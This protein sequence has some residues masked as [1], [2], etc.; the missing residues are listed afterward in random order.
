MLDTTASPPP[1]SASSLPGKRKRNHVEILLADAAN[2][3][4]IGT[5]RNLPK[6]PI[7]CTPPPTPPRKQNPYVKKLLSPSEHAGSRI[8]YRLNNNMNLDYN[9][10][11]DN[12]TTRQFIQ[13]RAAVNQE[14]IDLLQSCTT[15]C[16]LCDSKLTFS[17]VG[18][19]IARTLIN[20]RELC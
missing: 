2:C 7:I 1:P 6:V 20:L 10:F 11:D 13:E 15:Y 14:L 16:N 3:T 5:K 9:V 18:M 19:S 8:A 4:P 17:L 12:A